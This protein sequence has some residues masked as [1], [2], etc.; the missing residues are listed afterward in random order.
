MKMKAA[1]YYGPGDIRLQ[2]IERP[3]VNPEGAILKVKA[4]G[5]CNLLDAAWWKSWP[6]NGQ[7]IGLVRGHE[8]SGD[9]VEVGSEVTDFKVGDRIFIEPVF[10]PCYH[11]EA[12]RLKDYWRCIHW[13]DNEAGR[14]INGAF[15]EYLAI[16]FLT[17]LNAIKLPDTLSYHDLALIEPLALGAGMARRAEADKVVVVLGQDTVGLGTVAL[18]KKRGVPRV[19]ASDISKKR[20]EASEEAGADIVVDAL[21]KDIVQLVMQETR[22]VGADTVIQCDERPTAIF[23]AMNM[24]KH[25]GKIWTTGGFLR[26]NPSLIPPQV[27]NVFRMPPEAGAITDSAISLDHGMASMASGFGYGQRLSRFQEVVDLMLSGKCT[28]DKLVSHVFP[29]DKITEAFEIGMDYH[30]SIKVLVEP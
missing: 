29:L 5:V 13:V 23:Q 11:C 6:E 7:G 12:C 2:E 18:L 9:L 19:I 25:R 27:T 16:P 14:A 10:R 15:A 4:C 8:W 17:K 1:V 20:I 21:N 24:V 30:E 28:A 22:G 26:I 3:E